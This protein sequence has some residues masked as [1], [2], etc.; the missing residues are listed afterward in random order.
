MFVCLYIYKKTL[1]TVSKMYFEENQHDTGEEAGRF[2]K[3]RILHKFTNPSV[4]RGDLVDT[5]KRN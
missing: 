5:F 3:G 2:C 1:L 4:G